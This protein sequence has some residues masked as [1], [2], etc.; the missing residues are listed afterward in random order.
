MRRLTAQVGG[1]AGN[2][3]WD[4][5]E[6]DKTLNLYEADSSQMKIGNNNEVKSKLGN[7]F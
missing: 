1:L 3:V 2:K 7:S 5:D 4:H 6:S